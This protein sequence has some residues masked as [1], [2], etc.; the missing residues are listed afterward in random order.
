ML[1]GDVGGFGVGSD[2]TWQ[3]EGSLGLQV[4]KNIWA[5]AGYR[6]LGV[7]YEADGLIY[8]TITHGA[9]VTL[10]LSF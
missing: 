6:A 3:V 9:Q 5:E 10:G 4:T 1:R 2:L 7:D 8:D